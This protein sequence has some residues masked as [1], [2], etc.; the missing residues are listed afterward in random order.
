MKSLSVTKSIINLQ[1]DEYLS[2]HLVS[3]NLVCWFLL[4]LQ[5]TDPHVWISEDLHKQSSKHRQTSI[6]AYILY[7][8]LKK[9]HTWKI[10]QME[11]HI[12]ITALIASSLFDCCT[13]QSEK[14]DMF[15]L[16]EFY[17][18]RLFKF[19]LNNRKK[20]EKNV[21]TLTWIFG[22]E[23]GVMY[24]ILCDEMTFFFYSFVVTFIVFQVQKV[25]LF[26]KLQL[27]ACFFFFC[28]RACL[29]ACQGITKIES[30]EIS[31]GRYFGSKW[32][33]F[34]FYAEF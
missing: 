18:P 26:M 10:L 19:K 15:C 34:T 16:R 23:W 14:K 22:W 32:T 8:W 30:E 12:L 28:W 25:P 24:C 1:G 29:S 20:Y 11:T 3:A 5:N 4:L 21:W 13:V 9:T 2:Q 31:S 7:V 27:Q 6:Y 17:T 33:R